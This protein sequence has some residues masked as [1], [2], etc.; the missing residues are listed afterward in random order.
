MDL[1]AV[2]WAATRHTAAALD[3]I[4]PVDSDIFSGLCTA[5]LRP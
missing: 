3:A 2:F 4:D 5:M 1:R